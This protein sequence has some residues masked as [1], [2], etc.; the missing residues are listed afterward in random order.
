MENNVFAIETYNLTKKFGNRIAVN[1]LSIKIKEIIGVSLQE[2]AGDLVWET[3][4][5]NE[6]FVGG[7]IDNNNIQDNEAGTVSLEYSD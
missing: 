5:K 2:K 7:T 1:D 6:Q 4:Q 3:Y